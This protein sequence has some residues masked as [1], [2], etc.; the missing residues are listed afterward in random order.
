MLAGVRDLAKAPP[1]TEP[2]RLDVTS[3]EDIAALAGIESLDALVNN[4]GIAIAS[5]VETLPLDELRRQLEVNLVGQVAVTQALLPA[6]RASGGRI[7]FVG[8]IAGR[9]A[10]PFLSAYAA[11]KHA[12]EAV[13][14]SLRVEL[15]PWRVAVSVV[16][17][18]TIRTPMWQTAGAYAEGLA[19]Q[20]GDRAAPYAERAAA[21]RAIAAKRGANGAPAEAVAAV[22]ERALTSDRPRTRYVVGRDAHIRSAVERLPDRLRDRVYER[23]LLRS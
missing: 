8:S 17:P 5:P 16:Q 1:G 11:S 6:L 23:L 10:L 20:A 2:V 22:V 3:A 19:E 14:D 18:G 12:L 4:A 9:S 21:F 15:T 7:V 13:A